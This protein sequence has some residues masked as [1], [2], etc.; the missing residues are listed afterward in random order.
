MFFFL[1]YQT[2]ELLMVVYL[3][4]Y[5]EQKNYT[6][7][8]VASEKDMEALKQHLNALVLVL[9]QNLNT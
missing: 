7:C 5:T 3:T 1:F 6:V 2:K 9:V 4:L 8:T